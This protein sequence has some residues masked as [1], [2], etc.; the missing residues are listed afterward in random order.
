MLIIC[1]VTASGGGDGLGEGHGGSAGFGDSSTSSIGF[2]TSSPLG[3]G[4]VGPSVSPVGLGLGRLEA[5]NPLTA[6]VASELPCFPSICWAHG[7][8]TSPWIKLTAARSSDS[9]SS[10]KGCWDAEGPSLIDLGMRLE[11]N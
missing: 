9:L 1:S 5:G 10:V 6:F 2:L 8:L 7:C 4:G 3:L 11:T